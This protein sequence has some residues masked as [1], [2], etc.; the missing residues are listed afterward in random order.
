M[1]PTTELKKLSACT[2]AVEWA[3]QF[4]TLKDA[5]L[6]CERSDWMLWW[7]RKHNP[8]KRICVQM[9]VEFAEK[10]L[11]IYEVKYPDDDRPR[12]AIQAARDWLS[13][14]AAYAVYAAYA[15]AVYAAYA[16][17]VY[18]AYAAAAYAADAADAAAY[19]AAAAAYAADAVY[20][21][22]AADA[23]YAAAA[24]Y[25]AY[26]ADA[27]YADAAYA[28]AA[29]DAAYAAAA[30]YAAYAADAAE[31]KAQSDIIRKYLPT[32]PR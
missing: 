3:G 12:K 25:A 6:M 15:D 23:A 11:P 1:K 17:A 9:A 30:A 19:A 13:N 27:V 24:A 32:L 4:K 5:W 14:P 16:D 21:A 2:E 7:Y 20:A 26:A 31:R 29:A 22:A 18:A 28:D 8:D 10:V